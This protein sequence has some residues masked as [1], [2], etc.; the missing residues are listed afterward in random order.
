MTAVRGLSGAQIFLIDDT[1]VKLDYSE[2]HRAVQQGEWLQ[3]NQHEHL[4]YVKAILPN[5]YAMEALTPIL[6]PE[7]ELVKVVAALKESVWK[8]APV[9]PVDTPQTMLKVAKL[10]EQ[11]VPRLVEPALER[12][13]YI[14]T[15]EDCLAHGDP[16]AENV[17]LRGDTYVL[18]DPLPSAP[19]VPDDVAVDVGKLL[20]SA[21][22]WE[23]MKGDK[24]SAWTSE[25]VSDLFEP[26]VYEVGRLWCF[27][28][29]TRTLPYVSKEVR[30]RVVNKLYEL[31]GI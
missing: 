8:F 24:R 23:E 15:T 29:F 9:T 7:V 4:P 12:L 14:R 3:E 25:Q 19:A 31:L 28:H 20:Q 13:A 30:P 27:V 5:G 21:H 11:F 2:A 17:M 6:T 22:G 26:E 1:A 10:L 18:I 16:T